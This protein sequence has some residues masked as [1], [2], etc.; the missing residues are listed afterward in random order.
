MPDKEKQVNAGASPE[1]FSGV[2]WVFSSRQSETHFCP[3]NDL[4]KKKKELASDRDQLT[5]PPPRIPVEALE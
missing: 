4:D 2:R 3:L 1:Y 5:P